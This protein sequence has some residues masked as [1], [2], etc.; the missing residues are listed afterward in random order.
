MQ[1]GKSK[2]EEGRKKG[3]KGGRE[4]GREDLFNWMKKWSMPLT[5]IN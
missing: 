3:G 4:G 1:G 5:D 2:W